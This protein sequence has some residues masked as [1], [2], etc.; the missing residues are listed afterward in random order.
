MSYARLHVDYSYLIFDRSFRQLFKKKKQLNLPNL[1]L[2]P[3]AVRSELIGEIYQE[4]GIDEILRI[5]IKCSNHALVSKIG[6]YLPVHLLCLRFQN[7]RRKWFTM[8][9]PKWDQP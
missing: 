6:C 7:K 9:F 5:K 3:G 8:S 4:Q 2:I 1:T